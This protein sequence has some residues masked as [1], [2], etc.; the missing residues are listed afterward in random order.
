YWDLGCEYDCVSSPA[1]APERTGALAIVQQ[2]DLPK[3]G[4]CAGAV[5]VYPGI[6]PGGGDAEGL[7]ANRWRAYR[8]GTAVVLRGR[9]PLHGAG[10]LRLHSGGVPV[11]EGGQA[12]GSAADWTLTCQAPS[13]SV[14]LNSTAISVT[15]G[16]IGMSFRLF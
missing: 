16:L 2:H 4:A 3:P 1:A 6:R 14:A 9:L 15:N 7:R 12:S 13:T 5:P 10:V 8:T 11:E